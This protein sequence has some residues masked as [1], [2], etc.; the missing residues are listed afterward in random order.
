M[1][2]ETK[3]QLESGLPFF[4]I[5]HWRFHLLDFRPIHIRLEACIPRLFIVA[6]REFE[7]DEIEVFKDSRAS[8]L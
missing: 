6:H 5:R 4:R 3:L 2:N 7:V 8:W 1:G